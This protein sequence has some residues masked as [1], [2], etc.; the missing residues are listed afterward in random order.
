MSANKP[1]IV[2]VVGTGI[3]HAV[4]PTLVAGLDHAVWAL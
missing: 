4:Q 3:A 2:K 1:E